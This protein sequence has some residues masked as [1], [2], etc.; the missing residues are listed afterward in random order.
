M[1]LTAT[2]NKDVVK[3]S[4]ELLGKQCECVLNITDLILIPHYVI[5][6]HLKKIERLF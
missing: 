2:A 4:V 5:S 6:P 1:A 3:H